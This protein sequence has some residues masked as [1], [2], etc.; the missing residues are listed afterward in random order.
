MFIWRTVTRATA[1]QER[2]WGKD[3]IRYAYLPLSKVAVGLED[4]LNSPAQPT[5]GAPASTVGFQKSL[6]NTQAEHIFRPA[7]FFNYQI[8]S[9]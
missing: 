4:R 6:G 5:S 3:Q 1:G 9:V 7:L 2:V 8:P